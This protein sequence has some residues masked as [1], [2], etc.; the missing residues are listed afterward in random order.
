M[1]KRITVFA[2]ILFSAGALVAQQK[3]KT[4]WGSVELGYGIGLLETGASG[5]RG[6]KSEYGYMEVVN[7]RLK[8]GYYVSPNLSLGAGICAGNYTG[9]RINAVPVFADVRWHFTKSPKLF[10][11]ADIGASF[12]EGG[13]KDKGFVSE[14]GA[15]YRFAFG[16]RCALN[17]SVGYNLIAYRQT[18]RN[19]VLL[20]PNASAAENRVRHSIC[21]TLAFE[22]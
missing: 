17:P 3:Q 13:F 19:L 5:S 9:Y 21:F 12:F 20:D 7:T 11:F 1:R 6:T 14:L 4:L 2:L 10:A 18:Y 8:A 22:F 16:R 15:S